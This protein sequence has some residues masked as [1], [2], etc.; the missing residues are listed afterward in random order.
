[1]LL[2]KIPLA[3]SATFFKGLKRIIGLFPREIEKTD[4]LM[5]A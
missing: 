5:S 4:G 3:E 2:G 1:M